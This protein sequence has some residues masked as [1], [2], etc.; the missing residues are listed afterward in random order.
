[1]ATSGKQSRRR[2][3]SIYVPSSSCCSFLGLRSV[4]IVFARIA[5]RWEWNLR[6]I[7]FDARD[8]VFASLALAG[9]VAIS[10][11]IAADAI[12]PSS[13]LPRAAGE[14]WNEPGQGEDHVVGGGGAEGYRIYQ[15]QR[16][17]I[18]R[19]WPHDRHVA[20]PRGL[21][22][23]MYRFTVAASAL[24][25]GNGPPSLAASAMLRAAAGCDG[26]APATAASLLT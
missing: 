25:V 24:K 18:S 17:S 5:D 6:C 22:T 1:M 21:R 11:S 2:V 12:R 7:A 20:Y 13:G 15:G 4:G 3:S 14:C 9:V 8:S 10:M 16:C 26:D 19:P 23:T